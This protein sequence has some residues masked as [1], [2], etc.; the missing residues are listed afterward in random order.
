MGWVRYVARIEMGIAYGIMVGKRERKR[1][2]ER[3]RH[4]LEG[5]IQMDRKAR[6]DDGD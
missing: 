6:W 3:P 5:N 4:T 1:T 2:F